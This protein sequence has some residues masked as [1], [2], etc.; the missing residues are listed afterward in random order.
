[1]KRIAVFLLFLLY[2]VSVSG[3]SFS[4]HFCGEKLQRISIQGFRH[5]GC[6]CK[7]KEAKK[8][9]CHD[10]VISLE[11]AKAHK[12]A[13]E[14]SCCPAAAFKTHPREI[15]FSDHPAQFFP[16]TFIA[17]QSHAPPVLTELKTLSLIGVFRI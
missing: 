9:C 11:K 2:T 13:A 12:Q 14:S 15:S 16:L 10:R 6:C 1:M 5:N 3:A 7:K 4:V 8:D 17:F